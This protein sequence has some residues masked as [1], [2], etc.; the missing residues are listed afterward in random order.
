MRRQLLSCYYV[1]VASASRRDLFEVEAQVL[2]QKR[3][4]FPNPHRGGRMLREDSNK[5]V[6]HPAAA[7]HPADIVGDIDELDGSVSCKFQADNAR[8]RRLRVRSRGSSGD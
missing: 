6:P 5:S 2:E 7:H 1:G 4:S 8:Y 3:L